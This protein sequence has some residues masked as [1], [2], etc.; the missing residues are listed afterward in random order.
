MGISYLRLEFFTWHF[1]RVLRWKNL[2]FSNQLQ[3]R[4]YLSLSLSLSVSNPVLTLIVPTIWAAGIPFV[5][6]GRRRRGC[7]CYMIVVQ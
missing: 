5:A 2:H 6:A 1:V 7:H 3:H 4:G